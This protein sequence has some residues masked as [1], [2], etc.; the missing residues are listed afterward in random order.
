MIEPVSPSGG[1]GPLADFQA[2]LWALRERAG[3]P[4]FRQMATRVVQHYSTLARVEVPGR[5]PPRNAVLA[6]V[7]ACRGDVT[8][9]SRQ[10]R[11]LRG[12]LRTG[13]KV[14]FTLDSEAE[15][16]T[17]TKRRANSCQ[18]RARC[19]T[20]SRSWTSRRRG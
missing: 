20:L 9:W 18:T 5:I 7:E 15:R 11:D 3:N 14:T 2:A 10:Y 17:M 4:S 6:Y 13:Q 19:P 1:A 12:A 8:W 16:P